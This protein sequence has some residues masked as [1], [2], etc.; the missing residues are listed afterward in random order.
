MSRFF[1][2][3]P[4]FAWV[5]AIVVMIAGAVAIHGLPIQQYPDIA[6]PAVTIN[7]ILPGASAE[8]LENSVTQVIEQQLKGI[9]HLRYFRSESTSNG[10]VIITVTFEPEADHDIAQVQ[11]QNKLQAA[12]SSLPQEV[13]QRGVTV[14]KARDSFLLVAAF[15][16]E[17]G[18]MS[19][20]EISDIVSSQVADVIARVDGV[21]NIVSFGG[22]HAMRVWLDPHKL[23]SYNM[24][25]MDVRSSIAAQNGDISA[26]QL[27]A[28]PSVKGQQLNATINAQSRLRTVEQFENIIL[29]VN[30]DGSN[31]L[32]KDVARIELG[33]DDYQHIARFNGVP[34]AGLGVNLATGANALNTAKLV[35]E[36]IDT[37]RSSFPASLKISYPYDTTPFVKISIEGVVYTLI[38]AILLVFAVM[39]IFLQNFRAT[40]IPSIAVP[41]VL[42]GTLLCCIH[43]VI[44]SIH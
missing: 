5:I 31:V 6:P 26:G 18:S 44:P 38:E 37:L 22:A 13:Q 40:L 29:R 33:A 8:T 21:G 1:I 42:L 23:V 28:M 7:A 10:S 35:K 4:I 25:A 20:L 39:F 27:G 3:R 41:V 24:T 30:T 12:I 2:D 17:D 9:D 43:L 11:V 16:S 14:S 36:K 32:L 15:Y 19:Q 34:A